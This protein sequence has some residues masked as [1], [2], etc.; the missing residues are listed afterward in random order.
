MTT[1][2][3]LHLCVTVLLH[4]IYLLEERV[5]DPETAPEPQSYATFAAMSLLPI[6]AEGILLGS[7]AEWGRYLLR[8]R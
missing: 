1:L 4:V 5:P 3:L 8:K 2:L 7:L 6:V